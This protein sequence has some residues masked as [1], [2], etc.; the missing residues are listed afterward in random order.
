MKSGLI[1][2]L[3]FLLLRLA[4]GEVNDKNLDTLKTYQFGDSII[5]VAN[6]YELP[7]REVTNS[8]DVVAGVQDYELA[9]HSVLQLVDIFSPNSFLLEKKVLGFG[10][11]TN[12]SGN[13]S[14]RG[15]GSRPNTGM[16]VLINGR[17]DFMGIF[18]HPLPDV[19]GLEGIQQIDVI[20]GPSSTIF[21]SNAMGGV[22]NLVNES[23]PNFQPPSCLI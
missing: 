8:V 2:A 12:G 7:F 21:G 13:I 14:M 16:L 15:M 23:E 20:K 22:I 10:V 6:R 18:G 5:V 4:I 9:N 17:P 19:Y 11:G 1:P 3:T